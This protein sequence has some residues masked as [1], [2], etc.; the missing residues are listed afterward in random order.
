MTESL[1]EYKGVPGEAADEL[2]ALLDGIVAAEEKD[3][4]AAPVSAR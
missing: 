1:R 4:V 2:L 3:A